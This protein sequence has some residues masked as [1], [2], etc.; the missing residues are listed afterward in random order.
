MKSF[1]VRGVARSFSAALLITILL[2]A[3]SAS[4]QTSATPS[5]PARLTLNTVV[6][7]P[8]HGGKDAGCVSRDGKTYEKNLTLSI[9]KLL[10]QKITKAYPDV[11]VVYTRTTDR[12]VTLNERAETAN[13]NHADLFIS[14]HI[15]SFTN[16]SPNGFSAHV[17]GQSR[18]KNRDLFSYNID[19]CKR[20]NSVILLEDD[21]TTK[22]EGF[23]PNDPGSYIFL[24]LMQ[25]A[26]YEQSLIFAADV[27]KQMARG[28]FSHSRGISQ[29]PFYVL[30]KTAMPAV[31]LEF[32]FISNQADL[33][34]M[35][36]AS[37]QEKIA[38]GLLAAFAEFKRKYDGS[39]DIS[40][41]AKQ[42]QSSMERASEAEQALAEEAEVRSDMRY[43]VQILSLSKRLKSGDRAFKGYAPAI[44][45]SDKTYKY[46]VGV[47]GSEAEA[48]DTWRSVKRRFPDAFLVQIA[49]DGSITPLK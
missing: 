31:L 45:E 3:S 16:S 18:D 38:S 35:S 43:G 26:H 24:N 17:L 47:S 27:E 6:I 4:A 23:D 19:V 10:G 41:A 29:D 12:Y 36:S 7:D 44:Y 46:V 1:D 30:W 5:E 32:G 20:E 37:G 2:Q 28:P 22:Y 34:V 40:E 8:G 39:L 15:N 42:V 25:N 11:K 21:Y 13:R 14:I 49:P 9:A 33:K 48:R